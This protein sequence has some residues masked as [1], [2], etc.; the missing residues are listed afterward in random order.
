MA[1]VIVC[2]DFGAQGEEICCYFQL[3]LFYFPGS[4]GAGCVILVFKYLV[5]SWLFHCPPSPSSRGSLVSLHSLPLEWYL[6]YLRLL[7]FLPPIL[8]PAC[9]SS[10]PAFHLMCSVYKLNKQPCHTP[11]SILNQS[12][13]PYKV[14]T[15]ASWPANRFLRRQ[16]RWSR[17]PISLRVSTVS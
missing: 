15:I 9:N 2:S 13:V 4:N 17:I 11:F 5:L 1:A 10:I 8:I 16:V 14:L 6:T 12:V 7:M 3:F